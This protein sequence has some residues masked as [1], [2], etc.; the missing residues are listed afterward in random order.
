MVFDPPGISQARSTIF[1]GEACLEYVD[2]FKYLGHYIVGDLSD[3]LDISREVRSLYSRGNT[4]VRKFNFLTQDVKKSLF[5]SYCYPLYASPL[6][7]NFRRA[8]LY[9]LKVAYNNIM[10]KLVNVAP[11]ESAR[12]MFVSSSV[13][14]FDENLRV[15]MYSMYVRVNTNVNP[16]IINLKN[17]D[18]F[19]SSVQRN[20]MLNILFMA[21]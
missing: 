8:S 3:D 14:S 12:A 5:K 9:R 15:L 16:I 18:C 20:R 19:C 7:C 11:W 2:N 17:S 10:R 21:D 4:I 1:L 13:R 6:W